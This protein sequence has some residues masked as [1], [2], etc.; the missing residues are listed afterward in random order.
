MPNQSRSD[1]PRHVRV[2]CL[3][4]ASIAAFCTLGTLA[5][6]WYLQAD[7]IWLAATPDVLAEVAACEQS[8][9]RSECTHCK[10][11][12]VLARAQT[13]QTFVLASR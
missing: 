4:A 1:M 7:P 5:V 8:P 6:N 12:M 3:A 9:D 11:A 2:S 10:R 13:P